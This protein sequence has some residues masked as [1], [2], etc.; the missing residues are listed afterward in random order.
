MLDKE[1][2]ADSIIDCILKE[3]NSIPK[4]TNTYRTGQIHPVSNYWDI[5][6]VSSL[7]PILVGKLVYRA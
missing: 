4:A 5:V 2:V 1:V 7:C 6:L 3:V